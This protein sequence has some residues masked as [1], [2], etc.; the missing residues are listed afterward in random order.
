MKHTI[1]IIL[2][3]ALWQAGYSQKNITVKGSRVAIVIG[4]DAYVGKQFQQLDRS[5]I[6]DADS[7]AKV[8]RGCGFSVATYKDVNISALKNAFDRFYKDS[9]DAEVAVVYYSGHGLEVDGRNFMIPIGLSLPSR[10]EEWT[11]MA[12]DKFKNEAFDVGAGVLNY[13]NTRPEKANFLIFD[14]CRSDLDFEYGVVSKGVDFSKS[15]A[16]PRFNDEEAPLANDCQG[17]GTCI[18]YATGP[19]RTSAPSINTNSVF[20]HALLEYIRR[21]GESYLNV[22]SDASTMVNNMRIANMQNPQL[23]DMYQN[24]R[25]C[26][27]EKTKPVAPSVHTKCTRC[28]GKGTISIVKS[29]TPCTHCTDGLITKTCRL[30]GGTGSYDCTDCDGRGRQ[31]KN[32]ILCKGSGE[33]NHCWGTGIVM[34]VNKCSRCHGT[35][36]CK[37]CDGYKHEPCLH[38]KNGIRK[39]KRT[40][41]VEC[42]FCSG[43]GGL[44]QKADTTCPKCNGIGLL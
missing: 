33:C 22:F 8:L 6:H 5:S 15:K 30:C 34:R 40:D 41:E 21:Q 19:F 31:A 27:Y 43:S 38:C 25:F 23:S 42:R 17:K 28:R 24:R 14:A 9:K 12:K 4:N 44:V 7:M 35:G 37:N 3:L 20:T 26:F 36:V 10:R 18:L 1:L 39:C 11:R 2:L 16:G 32:C 29:S 13:F